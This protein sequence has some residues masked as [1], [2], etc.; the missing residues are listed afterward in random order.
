[1]KALSVLMVDFYCALKLAMPISVLSAIREASTYQIT[2]KGG[3]FLEKISEADDLMGLVT[4]K[5]ISN[6]LVRRIQKNYINTVGINSALILFGVTGIIQPATSALV[7]NTSTL[8]ISLS[9]MKELL[10]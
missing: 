6:G 1:M 9:S 3:K 10:K 5:N 4:L 2:V 7:H 8:A